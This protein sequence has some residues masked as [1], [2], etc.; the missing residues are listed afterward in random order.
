MDEFLTQR[1][2]ILEKRLKESAASPL[3]AQL[4]AFYLEQGRAEE[5]LRT[6]DAGL[7]HHPFYTTGHLIKGKA[8]L[9]LNMKK[10]A[11]RELEFVADFFP[12]NAEV[13]RL[14]NSLGE[15]EEEP[16]AP[17][18]TEVQELDTTVTATSYDV[19]PAAPQL[20]DADVP[21][22]WG[23]I[24]TIEEV[25]PS[26]TDSSVPTVTTEEKQ[27]FSSE[28]T[29]GF[30]TIPSY[31]TPADT[32]S[33][34]MPQTD[35]VTN[36]EFQSPVSEPTFPSTFEFS[37]E[38][39]SAPF[40]TQLSPEEF[41]SFDVYAARMR[42]EL[43]GENSLTLDSFLQKQPQESE[44]SSFF[45]PSFGTSPIAPE[46]SPYS[47]SATPTESFGGGI[48]EPPVFNPPFAA[49]APTEDTTIE[50]LTT[51]LQGASRITPIIDFT[52]K[53]TPI[54]S[55]DDGTSTG[56][57]TPTLAEIYAKQGWYDDAIKAYRTLARTKPEER[58]RFERRIQE[59]EALKNQAASQ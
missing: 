17:P 59:L 47:F 55:D 5:A 28:I 24:L 41:S 2:E 48:E 52:Q 56:F 13:Q 54:V 10:E 21:S 12:T 43:T 45:N 38:T 36:F 51:K 33:F 37:T 18:V 3:F 46:E 30:S 15:I 53:E 58:E 23:S 40:Q 26:Q 57:V 29:S 1:I 14:L 39:S 34:E 50:D 27:Q 19:Q 32:T 35:E 44:P 4:A 42:S 9:A 16:S 11:Q 25:E 31:G 7:A 49:A 8:L 6:C 22:G 20:T